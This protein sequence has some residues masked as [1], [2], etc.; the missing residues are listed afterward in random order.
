MNLHFELAQTESFAEVPR[1][2]V[3]Q[4]F[5]ENFLIVAEARQNQDG[6]VGMIPMAFVQKVQSVFVAD[7]NI[8]DQQLEELVAENLPCFG[9]RSCGDDTITSSRQEVREQLA[10]SSFIV[11]D[12]DSAF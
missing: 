11:H 8:Q 3:V 9:D 4:R 12:Q 1:G 2:A 10:H 5:L 6:Q 7:D